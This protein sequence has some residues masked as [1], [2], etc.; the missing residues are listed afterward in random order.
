MKK[1]L[2][3]EDD[4]LLRSNTLEFLK[5]EGFDAH[6]ASDGAEGVQ[7]AMEIIPDII[8]CDIMMPRMDGYE[9][10][11][12]L[13]VIPSTSSIPFIF[14]TAKTQKEEIRLG[15]QLGVDDY[16]TKP[17]SFDELLESIKVRIEKYERVVN[18]FENKYLSMVENPLVGVFII[19]NFQFR[20]LNNKFVKM[21]AY[22][23]EMDIYNKPFAEL[24]VETDASAVME[25]MELCR[26]NIIP[27]INMKCRFLDKD[28]NIV[29]VSLFASSVKLKGEACI[30]GYIQQQH[31]SEVIG[32][33][34]DS[35][36]YLS[37]ISN[38]V[39]KMIEY[40]KI[41]PEDLIHIMRNKNAITEM[42]NPD[43]LTKREIEIIRSLA[44]GLSNK[45]IAEKL[46]ISQR[47]VDTHKANVLMKTGSNHVGAL[48]M[49]ALKN[50]I[51]E[52]S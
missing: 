32:L 7:M 42:N 13:Q 51:I 12:A 18:A 48:I 52:Q 5:E 11:K 35:S 43:N 40:H 16:I 23:S 15:M 2:L 36:D 50:N 31:I 10:L 41:N 47:T 44:E 26:K 1:V 46:F 19:Y 27:N 37:E 49:Y 38:V 3:I 14:L 25:K 34:S 30:I 28:K 29:P 33:S 6:A 9:V 39:Q 8:L 4:P 17:Y 20:Y 45:E 21:L 22:R 24:L